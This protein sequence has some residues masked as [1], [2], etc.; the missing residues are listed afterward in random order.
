MTFKIIFLLCQRFITT[1]NTLLSYSLQ[2]EEH[3]TQTSSVF[4]NLQVQFI[5]QEEAKSANISAGLGH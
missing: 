3:D 1:D 2:I 4:V 5:Q